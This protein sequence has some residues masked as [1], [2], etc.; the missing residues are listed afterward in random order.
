MPGQHAASSETYVW[1]ADLCARI[2]MITCSQQKLWDLSQDERD[3]RAALYPADR[4]WI[5]DP[6]K[7]KKFNDNWWQKQQKKERAE[8]CMRKK[9]LLAAEQLAQPGTSLDVHFRAFYNMCEC[10]LLITFGFFTCMNSPAGASEASQPAG[11][12]TTFRSFDCGN[13]IV[14]VMLH[15]DLFHFA[16]AALIVCTSEASRRAGPSGPVRL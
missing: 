5:M 6:E 4:D 15:L 14:S 11:L 1:A 8:T 2:R 12:A 7:F 9:Q 3:E 10:S 16:C 13:L